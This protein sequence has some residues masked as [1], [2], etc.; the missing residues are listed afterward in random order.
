[1][2]F[3]QAYVVDNTANSILLKSNFTGKEEVNHDNKSLFNKRQKT[4]NICN[5]SENNNVGVLDVQI[6]DS[7]GNFYDI[8]YLNP[9]EHDEDF[10]PLN[11]TLRGYNMITLKNKGI[12]NDIKQKIPLEQIDSSQ[13]KIFC[14]K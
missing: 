9:S 10:D 3:E 8:R 12:N 7:R 4:F 13:V 6:N 14:I 11:I 1:M 2:F 5:K